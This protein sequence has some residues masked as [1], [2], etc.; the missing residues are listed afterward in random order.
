MKKHTFLSIIGFLVFTVGFLACGRDAYNYKFN[1][2]TCAIIAQPYNV[3]DSNQVERTESMGLV[4]TIGGET[5]RI[6]EGWGVGSNTLMADVITRYLWTSPLKSLEVVSDKDFNDVVAGAS[7]NDKLYGIYDGRNTTLDSLIAPFKVK[8]AFI[9]DLTMYLK[10]KENP[11]EK[12]HT[13]RFIFT[14][15]NGEVFEGSTNETVWK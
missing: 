7:L 1:P 6:A 3:L 12:V 5:V 15:E 2:K 10:F 14:L 11:S 8:D 13:I 4:V 9:R